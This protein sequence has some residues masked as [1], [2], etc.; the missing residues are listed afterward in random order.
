M[1]AASGEQAAN[2]RA[3]HVANARRDG[4][5][6]GGARSGFPRIWRIVI[7]SGCKRWRMY[8]QRSDSANAALHCFQRMVRSTIRIVVSAVAIPI[9]PVVTQAIELV[10]RLDHES[11][12][13]GYRPRH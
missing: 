7:P 13:K 2:F 11:G 5:V 12:G 3:K 9:C 8:E 6:L 1:L 4:K 10:G